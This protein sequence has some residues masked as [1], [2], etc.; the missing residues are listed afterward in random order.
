MLKSKR[1]REI[2]LKIVIPERQLHKN[3]E[4]LQYTTQINLNLHIKHTARLPN[5]FIWTVY[6]LEV[7]KHCHKKVI[8][9]KGNTRRICQHVSFYI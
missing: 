3:G 9:T 7:S 4:F 6:V 5:W 1:K 2:D 8:Y